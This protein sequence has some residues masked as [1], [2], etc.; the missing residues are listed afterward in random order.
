MCINIYNELGLPDC[1]S[2]GIRSPKYTFIDHSCFK[3]GKH[4]GKIISWDNNTIEVLRERENED[5]N[6]QIIII[7]LQR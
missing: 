5:L 6:G 4:Y 1:G 2:R 3:D 7:H